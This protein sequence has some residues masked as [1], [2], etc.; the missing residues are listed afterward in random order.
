MLDED[1]EFRNEWERSEPLYGIISDVISRRLELGL[2]QAQLAER[3]GKK[4]PAIARFEAGNAENPTLSF[5]QALAD[6]LDMQL[7]VRLVPK[8]G[9]AKLSQRV[10]EER[11]DYSA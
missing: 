3:M 5:L 10:A 7:S 9:H 8:A 1:P 2:T 6:A 4:Q 11:A